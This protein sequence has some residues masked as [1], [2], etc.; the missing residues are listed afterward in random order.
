MISYPLS[1]SFQSYIQHI[2]IFDIWI[3]F[4]VQILD[5]IAQGHSEIG[6]I[7]LNNQN[8]KGIMQKDKCLV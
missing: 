7:Y 4:N 2:R 8:T 3:D 1:Q 5:E 6:I